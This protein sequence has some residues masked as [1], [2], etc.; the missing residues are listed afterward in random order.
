MRQILNLSQGWLF[1]EDFSHDYLLI[2]SQDEFRK[3]SFESVTIPH[4]T[5]EIPYNYFDEA[6]Y[7]F[8]STYARQL[9]ITQDY[10]G[11]RVFVDFEGVMGYSE[12]FLNGQ[13]L[14]IHKGGYTPFTVEL[15]EHLNFTDAPEANILIVKAD[16]TERDDIPPFGNV[17]D[18][19]CYG[20]MYRD[21]SLRIVHPTYINNLFARPKVDL[22]GSSSVETTVFIDN[23]MSGGLDVQLEL[24]L[25]YQGEVVAT[26]EESFTI[27]A[28][29][30]TSV[31]MALRDLTAIK[32]WDIDDPN[33]YK[34]VATLKLEGKMQDRFETTIGFREALF[35][36][37]GFYLNGRKLHIRGLNRHQSYP[38]V[39]YA[40][41]ERVQK[42]D[43]DILKHE[44]H[45]NLVRTSHYPQSTHFL[46]RCDEIG[47]LVFEEI[48]GWQHI[49]GPDWK[50]VSYNDVRSMITRDW[51]HPSIILWGVRINESP[52]DH[53]F[54]VET[55]RIARELDKT[56]PTGGVR[57]H[58]LSEFLE[59]VF[60]VNDFSHS[61]GE[62]ILDTQKSWTGLDDQVPYMVT[63][64][65]GHMY[66]TKR[67][68][69]EERLM[70]HAL[71]HARVQDKAAKSADIHGAI[72]WCAFDYNTHYEFGSGDR[73]CYHGV[74]DMF[75]IPKFAAYVYRSQVSPKIDPVLEPVTL[76]ARGERNI[77]GVLPL[78]ILTNCDYVEVFIEGQT[79]GHFYPDR[80]TFAGL[81]YPPIIIEE[82]PSTG[83]WGSTWFDGEFVGYHDGQE[84][85]RKNFIKNPIPTQ[86][87][88]EADDLKLC[89]NG[90]DATRVV[91][92][93]LDQAGNLL[94]YLADF[95]KI[96]LTGAGQIVGPSEVS[97]IGGCIATWIK[98]TTTPGTITVRASSSRLTSETIQIE[99]TKHV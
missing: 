84:I 43:A 35:K 70:E 25:L 95:L 31:E 19:L 38:Y 2:R 4:T 60:T 32:L 47:L 62:I 82:I 69:Q 98:T 36:P 8:V 68:D 52:D 21:V 58:R 65:N 39:G 1:R 54:Y 81:E 42:R 87:T 74:M 20:G 33:L 53:D 99:T 94:P 14:H 71:R 97:L 89:A 28:G 17:I 78:V 66:P 76:W 83:E 55:N 3:A 93:V 85:L 18:Y 79:F 27:V 37:D 23:A 77:G 48:P 9:D 49:G 75:R 64:F 30:T 56:R 67:F 50:D 72:G 15:T 92:K 12:V 41:P 34:I 57:C 40:M 22:K 16:S 90:Q 29:Q 24:S 45:V 10:R 73:I 6:M 13:L 91:F 26:T 61:G 88:I 46:D 44:L 51:N 63:E 7:Q 96:E 11:K 86:L 5:R 59:D 80:E